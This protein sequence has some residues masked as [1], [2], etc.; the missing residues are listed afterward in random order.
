MTDPRPRSIMPGRN[1]CT[2]RKVPVRSASMIRRH[3]SAGS[4]TLGVGAPLPPA[5][6]ASTSTGPSSVVTRSHR[7]ASAPASVTS[8]RTATA[9][10]AAVPDLLADLLQRGLVAADHGDPHPAAGEQPG[11]GGTDAARATG[12]HR[13]PPGQPGGSAVTTVPSRRADRGPGPDR[14]DPTAG[15]PKPPAVVQ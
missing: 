8:A 5:K 7:A 4:R 13:H 11:G 3:S 15:R 10:A 1:A 12:H 9:F 14:P 6:A 2:V